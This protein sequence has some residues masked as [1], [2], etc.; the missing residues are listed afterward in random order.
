MTSVGGVEPLPFILPSSPNHCSLGQSRIHIFK[1][2]FRQRVCLSS[3]AALNLIAKAVGLRYLG[4]T[5]PISTNESNEQEKE[6][7]VTL[8][9]ELRRQGTF[10]SEEEAKTRC[11]FSLSIA[12]RQTCKQWLSAFRLSQFSGPPQSH[13]RSHDNTTSL[14]PLKVY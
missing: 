8:M 5:P 13:P 14:R 3:L 7:T 10:E 4:I 1:N 6:V 11:V 9:E 2:D 12:V